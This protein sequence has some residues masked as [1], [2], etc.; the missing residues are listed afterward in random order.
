MRGDVPSVSDSL[1]S[2]I[3][4]S[5][6]ARGCSGSP[7]LHPRYSGVFPACAGMFR[8]RH[9]KPPRRRGFP[10]VRGDVP[11][12][13]SVHRRRGK[14][15]PRARGCSRAA[16]SCN[17]IHTVFPACAGMFRRRRCS[18]TRCNRFPRVRGDVPNT[19][20]EDL[21]HKTF[22]PRARGCSEEPEWIDTMLAVFPAC[23]GMFRG[24]GG[25]VGASGGFPRV[26]G[27][28]PSIF[29]ADNHDTLF[30]PRARGCSQDGKP[31]PTLG[32]VFPACAGM[33]RYAF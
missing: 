31:G 9:G 29:N 14:F 5:P 20:R 26:R 16:Q 6:R 4:F 30:S 19:L 10:R 11:G 2:M 32:I 27:D 8:T 22:S 24:R 18:N 12:R 3:W 21:E 23:A 17:R 25:S 15:S 13:V 7:W 1:K 33:F 28:V